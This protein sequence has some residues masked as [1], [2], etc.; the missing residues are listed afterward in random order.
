MF[1]RGR[2]LFEYH[3]VVGYRFIPGLKARIDHEG[4]GYLLRTNA[5]GFRSNREFEAAKPPGTNR[6]LLFG[7]SFTAG[8]GVSNNYRYSDLLEQLLPEVEIYNFGLPGTGTDQQLLI[9]EEFA[10]H[11]E[12]DLV[13]IS[14]LAENIRRV[15]ARYRHYKDADGSEFVLAKPY[16]EFRD[17]ELLLRNVP[18]PKE[19]LN[20]RDVQPRG[21]NTL[22][23]RLEHRV[24]RVV[25][26]LGPGAK[27]LIQRITRFQPL[28]GYDR[29]D[30]PEWALLKAILQRW[31]DQCRAP[32]VLCPLPIYQYVE[33]TASPV[34]FQERFAE[35][36]AP[37]E[38]RVH[39]P[40]PDY[41]TVPA[42]DRR[43]LRFEHDPHP[44]PAGHELI[45]RSLAPLFSSLVTRREQQIA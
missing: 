5:S 40:L 44:T 3:P 12:H 23:G 36:H 26:A 18:C 1:A 13:V 11:I 20:E 45:A 27:E 25:N 31:I 2:S 41:Y 43:T 42:K 21:D 8:D 35:L 16:F 39:D 14:I 6:V 4:G 33:Q 10:S 30:S 24:R 9:Y 19:P 38:V 34:H 37:P 28:P 32:V 17:E 29:T 22:G 7:D 15:A